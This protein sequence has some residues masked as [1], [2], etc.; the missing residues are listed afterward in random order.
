MIAQTIAIVGHLCPCPI[1]LCMNVCIVTYFCRANNDTHRYIAQMMQHLCVTWTRN[2]ESDIA[3][4]Q[5]SIFNEHFPFL[6]DL[7]NFNFRWWSFCCSF[8][9][10]EINKGNIQMNWIGHDHH[11]SNTETF[12][13]RWKCTYVGEF[14]RHIQYDRLF[15]TYKHSFTKRPSKKKPFE[16]NMSTVNRDE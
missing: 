4:T 2:R 13:S 15:S 10:N 3:I 5:F 12:K 1:G 9:W 7:I 6:L 11:V 8:R 16:W 14:N